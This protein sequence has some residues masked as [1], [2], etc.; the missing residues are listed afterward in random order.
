MA[1][2]GSGWRTFEIAA[3]LSLGIAEAAYKIVLDYAKDRKSGG[4]PVRE[5]SLA[6][7]I[8][9]DMAIRIEMTRSAV[10]NFAYMLDHPDD[11]PSAYSPSMI[12]KGSVIRVFAAETGV[13]VTN[14]AAELMGSNGI[15]PEHHMEKYLRDSKIIQLILGGQQVSR[16]RVV[17][18]YYNYVV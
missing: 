6:A 14:K 9:T 17:R 11:Y 18:G 2:C 13:W 12:S 4:R 5:W 3:C 16:Y 10:Y 7:G 15:A 1:V 8:F